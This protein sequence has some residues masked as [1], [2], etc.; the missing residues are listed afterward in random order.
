L[1]SARL[2]W[3]VAAV[4]PRAVVLVLHG[5]RSKGRAAVRP[6][7]GAVLRMVPFVGALR[8]AGGGQVA[9]ATLRYAVSGWNGAEASP[10]GDARLAL[11]QIAARHPGLPLGLLGHSMGGRAALHLADDPAVRAIAALAPWV[12]GRDRVVGHD[13]LH[14]LVM[15]GTRDRMTSPA[16]SC[17]YADELARQ[18]VD[19]TYEP[20]PDS[21]AMLARAG[22]WHRRSAGFLIEHL[23]T[24]ADQGSSAER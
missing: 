1:P 13:G 19:V 15:H 5:G 4:D 9:V 11:E 12:E 16:A 23:L 18:G 10:V 21:H 7:Q 3:P 6:W 20:V 2:D 17:R 22:H 8:R 14:V 24:R